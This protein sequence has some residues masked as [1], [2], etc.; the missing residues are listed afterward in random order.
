MQ[1][2][3][4]AEGGTMGVGEGIFHALM[5]LCTCGVWYPVYRHRKNKLHRTVKFYA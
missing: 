3:S 4:R 5:I 2:V 1:E